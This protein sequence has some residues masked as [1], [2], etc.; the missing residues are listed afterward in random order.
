MPAV[1]CE[2]GSCFFIS[3][4]HSALPMYSILLM[5]NTTFGEFSL[6]NSLHKYSEILSC[7]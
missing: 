1:L 2:S 6:V 5:V 4:Q 3:W 7:M